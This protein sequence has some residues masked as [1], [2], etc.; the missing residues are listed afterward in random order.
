MPSVHEGKTKV[1]NTWLLTVRLCRHN[2]LAGGVPRPR[3]LS[4]A[5][6]P[7]DHYASMYFPLLIVTITVSGGSTC[8]AH[9]STTSIYLSQFAYSPKQVLASACHPSKSD[10][11][12]YPTFQPH[13]A[14]HEAVVSSFEGLKNTRYRGILTQ[15]N[16][17]RKNVEARAA[18]AQLLLD[19]LRSRRLASL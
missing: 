17:A 8:A 15:C 7:K 9:D 14:P 12:F 4:R 10:T 2:K 13:S 5:F 18:N 6:I 3:C 11:P 19:E 1:E 16:V